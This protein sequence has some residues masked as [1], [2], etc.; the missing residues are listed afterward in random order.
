M[1]DAAVGGD[2][3][4]RRLDVAVDL[5]GGVQ[6]ASAARELRRAPSRSRASSPAAARTCE[7]VAPS[8]SS[9]VKNQCRPSSNSSPSATRFG[10]L[11][12]CERAELVL[13]RSIA[14][15]SS[16][17]QR[18]QRDQLAA[19]VVHAENTSPVAPDRCGART[20]TAAPRG[21][22]TAAPPYAGSV[23][24]LRV[25]SL[26]RAASHLGAA[27]CGRQSLHALLRLRS[28]GVTG[29]IGA[30]W[31]VASGHSQLW[32]RRLDRQQ[33]AR[34]SRRQATC[35]VERLDAARMA[36]PPAQETSRGYT[37]PV[38]RRGCL[39]L[40]FLALTLVVTC[41]HQDRGRRLREGSVGPHKRRRALDGEAGWTAVC[42]RLAAGCVGSQP[43]SG[44][45]PVLER[46]VGY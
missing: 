25:D 30:R 21:W 8:T 2:Q 45:D 26:T 20:R 10:W 12:S 14:S 7:E 31:R 24:L 33:V 3:H 22:S 43:A 36:S 41:A 5:A 9:I 35:H 42:T 17:A 29:L 44:S 39:A 38:S 27:A 19:P 18:L 34:A 40:A 13:E 11:R 6:R 16:V 15:P 46:G 28:R 37:R 23:A 4:V 32:P 1:H